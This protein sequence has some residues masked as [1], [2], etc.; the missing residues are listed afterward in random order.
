YVNFSAFSGI[1]NSFGNSAASILVSSSSSA[2]FSCSSK[3]PNPFSV[4][5]YY[6]PDD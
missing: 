6:Q 4:K 3:S 1:I 5:S 2:S